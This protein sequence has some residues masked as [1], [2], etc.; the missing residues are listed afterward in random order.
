MSKISAVINT[1]NEES[2]IAMC[3]EALMWCDEIIVV[4]MKSEDRTKEI[5]ANYTDKIY[6]FDKVGYVEPARKVAVEKATGDW[7]LIVDADEL[8]SITLS[9]ELLKIASNDTADIVFIPFKTYILGAW[10]KHTGW[11]PE[12]HPRFFKRG[13]VEFSDRIHS[14]FVLKEGIRRFY[15]H[16]DVENAIEHFAYRDLSHFIEKLNR[17]TTVEASHLYETGIRFSYFK[18]ITAGVNEFITRFLRLRGYKD[19]HRGLF[20]SLIMMMYRVIV[21]MKLWEMAENGTT[22]VSDR[23]NQMKTSLIKEHNLR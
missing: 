4:D 5:A 16:T 11:W 14:D 15:L 3:L 2:N 17:Y 13:C 18:M 8:V 20:L 9:K 7:I 22:T 23:Y 12:Y 1:L 6:E 21:C 10:I 19:G